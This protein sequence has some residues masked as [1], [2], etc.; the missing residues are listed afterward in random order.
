MP[1]ARFILHVDMDAFFA[2]VEQ[3]DH[4]ELRGKPILVGGSG[5]RGV[6]STASYEARVFGCRSAQ[7][8]AVA[9]RLC[10]QAIVVRGNYARYSEISRQVRHIFERYTPQ[11]QPISIDEAFLDVTLS[12]PLFGPAE[13]IARKIRIDIK[14]ETG[15]TGSVGVAPNKFLAKLASDMNKPD[16]LTVLNAENIKTILPPLPIEKMW[17]IGPK[18]ATKL[19]EIGIKTFGDLARLPVDLLKQ[20]AGE[21]GDRWQRLARG[22][23]SREVSSDR[24]AKSIGQEQ[25]FGENLTDPEEVRAVIMQECESV[26]ARL[27]KHEILARSV[28]VKIRYG[29]FQTITRRCTLERGTNVT[30][31]LWRAAR[32]LFD[33]WASTAFQPVRLIG[34]QAGQLSQG[35]EQFD[36][37]PD[38]ANKKQQKVDQAIDAINAKFGKSAVNRKLT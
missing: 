12:V 23:D 34:V 29:N 19:R 32:E 30:L 26:A 35:Q 33:T 1:D 4:P 22:E 16:G 31:D 18:T 25:T 7:P 24:E 9:R 3:L 38:Q 20:R 37:F 11:V 36:L 2:S 10:P 21:D 27:R 15:V 17:G 5:R 13:E 8:M 6:V 14:R 28:T